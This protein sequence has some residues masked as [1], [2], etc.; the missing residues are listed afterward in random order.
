M[1]KTVL[2]LSDDLLQNVHQE[3]VGAEFNR[4]LSSSLAHRVHSRGGLVCRICSKVLRDEPALRG[5]LSAKHAF[6]REYRCGP[7]Q[8]EFCYKSVYQRHL[9]LHH[10]QTNVSGYTDS[11]PF[12]QS[13]CY[14]EQSQW[15]KIS[16]NDRELVDK[17]RKDLCTE[18][19]EHV[20]TMRWGY[21]IQCS[22]NLCTLCL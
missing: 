20:C 17:V 6:P 9:K 11:G 2:V 3:R 13:D 21:H 16:E 14:F 1:A 5:H 19:E 12:Q 18:C 10:F 7:C 15:Q 8:K 4:D 22:N